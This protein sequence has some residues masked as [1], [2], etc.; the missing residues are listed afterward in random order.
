MWLKIERLAGEILGA[1]NARDHFGI[2][3]QRIVGLIVQRVRLTIDRLFKENQLADR[4]AKR[5]QLGGL[6]N[7]ISGGRRGLGGEIPYPCVE[8]AR[9]VG[10]VDRRRRRSRRNKLRCVECAPGIQEIGPR[11]R[12]VA[13]RDAGGNR[14]PRINDRVDAEI[15]RILDLP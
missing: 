7:G 11:L 6:Q 8:G 10:G 12:P 2:V 15:N 9:N 3:D 14:L 13:L 1:R 4:V 5:V